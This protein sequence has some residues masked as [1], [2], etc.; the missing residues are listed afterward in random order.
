[1]TAALRRRAQRVRRAVTGEDLAFLLLVAAVLAAVWGNDPGRLVP[2]TVPDLY[3]A[4]GRLLRADLSSWQSDP[5]LGAPGLQVGRVPVDAV[6]A[7]VRAAGA[8]PWVS[9]RL[10]HSVLLV[11][12]ALG[13]ARLYRELAPRGGSA[14]GRITA[15]AVYTV[16]PY[17][18]V[19]A[20]TLPTLLPYV[21]LPW[22]LVAVTESARSARRW[23]WAAVCALVFFGMSGIQVGVVP[24]LQL[25]A[26]PCLLLYLHW[27][28][29][30]AWSRLG[31][32]LVRCGALCLLVS[33][34]WLVPGLLALGAGSGIAGN[35]ETLEAIS[36]PSSYAEVLRGL[37]MW[38]M[39]GAGPAGPF[40][41]GFLVY[42]TSLPVVLA[43]T[44]LPV[45]ALAGAALSRVRLRVLGLV[46]VVV[47]APVMV[48][49]HP[50]T[51]P[52]LF[53]R[54]LGWGFEHVPGLVAFRTTNKAGG[55]LMVGT[56]LL[57]ALLAERALPLL[58]SRGR[59]A[60]AALAGAV[61]L[62]V[63]AAPAVLG[64]L[65]PVHLDLPDYW[66]D[67]AAGLDT[68]PRQGR[69]LVVPGE[70]QATYRWGYT[71]SADITTSL[72][73][74]SHVIR[75]TAPAGS[76][77]AANLLAAIDVPLNESALPP[78]S[79][80]TLARY[81]GADSVLV[82][83]DTRWED[84][85]GA[86]PA[87]V[88]A[89]VAQDSG[90][91]PAAAYGRPG[92]QTVSPAGVQDA[93]SQV[94]ERALP[95]LLQYTVKDA[96]PV[97]R[98]ESVAGT[99]LVDGDATAL[100]SLVE[101]GTLSSRPAV[102]LMGDLTEQQLREALTASPRL[103]LTDSNRRRL[104]NTS[105]L[106]SSTGPTLTAQERPERTRALYDDPDRQ[107]VRVLSGLAAL[108]STSS[109]SEFAP[110][111][112]GGPA[113]ALDGDPLSGWTTGDYGTAIGQALRLRLA[114]PARVD[115]VVLRPLATLPVRLTRV[116]L[117]V[118]DVVRDVALQVGRDTVV[119]VGAAAAQDV[120]VTV[121]GT[122]GEGTNAVGLAE[123]RLP[124]HPLS[125]SVRLPLTTGRLVAGLDAAGRQRLATTPVDVLL[126]RA[127]GDPGLGVDDE[128][129]RLDRDFTLPQARTYLPSGALRLTPA[130]GEQEVDRLVGVDPAYT[131]TSTSHY[132]DEPR[133]RASS[134]FDGDRSTAWVPGAGVVG[135]SVT[136]Q[137]PRRRLREVVVHQDSPVGG[138]V[139]LATRVRVETDGAP[140][141]SARLTAGATRIRLPRVPTGQLRLV[142]TDRARRGAFVRIT[143]VDV[144]GVR[145]APSPARAARTC[146]EV[147][148]L[149]GRPLQVH[150][151]GTT[152]QLLA[153]SPVP[154]LPCTSRPLALAAGEHT[155]RSASSWLV[156]RLQLADTRPAPAQ[157]PPP[158]LS[159]RQ[160][161]ATS[162][163][164][165][166]PA[167]G[168]PWYLVLGQ[169]HDARWR[170]TADGRDLGP[171][172]VLD[173]W[174]TGWRVDDPRAQEISVDYRPQAVT[175][176]A[177]TVSALALLGCGWALYRRRG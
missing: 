95:P 49:L 18:V 140:P 60:G 42:L 87:A 155:L 43:S 168:G 29:G 88:V 72:L 143:D 125:T 93:L 174:S 34:Y 98:A 4:P 21:L 1:M 62:A 45:A 3:E 121:L 28:E 51:S 147:A 133:S 9:L 127:Q 145:L 123:L 86:R 83:N 132:G 17:V 32:A 33:A 157:Q 14:A 146:S 63:A 139:D 152:G 108:T 26:L 124:G 167:A 94:A 101:T 91:V 138:L 106:G 129:R 175:R 110:V 166:A 8:S 39:Y 128:E 36:G 46:L 116:R 64:T 163:T 47:A 67:A 85:G 2:D 20:S 23:R 150:P 22:L 122:E 119:P 107:S 162:Y 171:P 172:I 151:G 158:L 12:G 113:L 37:G 177:I 120:G 130:A 164:V 61:V 69:T 109:G 31:G 105:R 134:A 54:A 74:R 159:V 173:A 117:Q 165:R 50:Y 92:E 68:G 13:A 161:S 6:M 76:P 10:L 96:V 144:A 82:R 170:A 148:L 111:P 30:L 136:V 11:L 84:L 97:T 103:V 135:E 5:F 44:A 142:V 77:E 89:Q 114:A 66:R 80:S 154:L 35:T 160:A 48:G 56:A 153:G 100:P 19:G 156:D 137:F 70:S 118:G 78:G 169:A 115:T 99:V 71:S 141:V 41:P 15:A 16:N 27:S 75:Q 59:Q 149:D 73:E 40:Q 90:L 112:Y 53:G 7:L 58:R 55:V 104:S 126:T 38:T 65:Y 176:G 57:V 52:T 79:L 102:R 25:L 24:L 131:A 81:L